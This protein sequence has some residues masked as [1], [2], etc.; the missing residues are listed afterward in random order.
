MKEPLADWAEAGLGM[1]LRAANVKT[2]VQANLRSD[3]M[4]SPVFES[5]EDTCGAKPTQ[6]A[7]SFRQKQRG[8]EICRAANEAGKSKAASQRLRTEQVAK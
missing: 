1:R 2:A 5:D 7:L 3:F 6:R 8:Q 4:E